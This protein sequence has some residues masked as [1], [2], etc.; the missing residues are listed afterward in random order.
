[1]RTVLVAEDNDVN[2][3]LVAEMLAAADYEVLQAC[4][5]EDAIAVL[6]ARIP[7]IVLLDMQMP[8]MDG[9]ETLQAIR[10]REEWKNLPVIACTAFAMHGERE[11]ALKA[12]F[13]AYVSKPIS[14]AGL[15]KTLAL[16]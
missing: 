15:L 8:K 7:D 14:M 16:F 10:A 12:G 3:E 6:E 2:R 4:D 9:L 5:G 1:M 13:D 11:G